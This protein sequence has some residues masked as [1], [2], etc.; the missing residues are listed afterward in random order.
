MF[1]LCIFFNKHALKI[2]FCQTIG[3]LLAVSLATIYV[4]LMASISSA[5]FQLGLYLAI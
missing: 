5:S 1:S 2:V 4:A 3:K